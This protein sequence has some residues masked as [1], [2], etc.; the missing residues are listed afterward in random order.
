[1]NKTHI[2][3]Y[4]VLKESPIH[5]CGIY[6]KRAIPKGIAVI[7]YIGEKITKKESD[8]RAEKVR[9]R[10]EKHGTGA[11][12]IFTLDNR[13][14]IDGDVPENYARFI[15]HACE[16]NCEAAIIDDEIWIETTRNVKAGEELHYD[17]GWSDHPCLCKA[18]KCIG[19]IVDKK[20]RARLVKTKKYQ[21]LQ[22]ARLK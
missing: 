6:A 11:V 2:N 20:H 21:L 13:Y 8:K 19:F 9:K 5:G 22:K 18:K 3:Q 12:Y 16:T 10:A 1:M 17:Y 14:D 15:N 7:Q 4:L